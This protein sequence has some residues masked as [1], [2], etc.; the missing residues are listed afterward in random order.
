MVPSSETNRAAFSGTHSRH[1]LTC[2]MFSLGIAPDT[3]GH[4]GFM[5]ENSTGEVTYTLAPL[6]THS[7]GGDFHRDGRAFYFHDQEATAEMYRA[8]EARRSPGSET[9]LVAI[10]VSKEWLRS[11]KS[12]H[13]LYG[14]DWKQYVWFCKNGRNTNR[15][16]FKKRYDEA[17]WIIG[18]VFT[19]ISHIHHHKGAASWNW[20]DRDICQDCVLRIGRDQGTKCSQVMFKREVG[21]KLAGMLGGKIHVDVTPPQASME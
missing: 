17:D 3:T 1:L 20:I 11:L 13:C 15:P 10:Q 9:W 21:V 14:D 4:E 6:T 12:S 7:D 16:D 18:H 5:T 8:Y 2:D 19:G